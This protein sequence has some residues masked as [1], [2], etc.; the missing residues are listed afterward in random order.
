MRLRRVVP[1]HGRGDDARQDGD[2]VRPAR[3]DRW[4]SEAVTLVEIQP[5][6][7][8][9]DDDDFDHVVCCKDEDITLCGQDASD[10]PWGDMLGSICVVCADL[11][12]G[13]YCPRGFHCE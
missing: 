3:R 2:A 7:Q 6:E 4:G 13:C 1:P 10:M 8:V 5:S 11:V 9:T 12:E